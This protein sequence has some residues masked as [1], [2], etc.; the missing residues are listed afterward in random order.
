MLF[1]FPQ[2]RFFQIVFTFR[3]PVEVFVAVGSA[4]ASFVFCYAFVRMA[5][6]SPRLLK[7]VYVLLFALSSLVQYGFWKAV[8]RFMASADLTIAAATPLATWRV[9]RRVV[10]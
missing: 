7:G 9:R 5:L 2:L 6:V 4:L 10:F 8:D 3:P 1:D